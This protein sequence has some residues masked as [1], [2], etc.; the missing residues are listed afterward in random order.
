ME[1]KIPFNDWSQDKLVRGLKCA[2]SR[3]KKYGVV[4]DTFTVNNH[5]YR[6]LL[7]VKLPLW[8]IAN[9]LFESEGAMSPEEFQNVWNDIHPIK[10]WTPDLMVW[11][12][13]FDL[14]SIGMNVKKLSRKK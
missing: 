4:G 3:T 14:V 7:V 10:G 1:I 6:L 9:E 2:T 11:Y 12:H 5:Q 13:Y 8:F